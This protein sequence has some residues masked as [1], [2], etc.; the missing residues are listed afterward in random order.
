M[1]VI[2]VGAGLGGLMLGALLEKAGISYLILERAK[3]VK[4]LGSAISV[5]ICM[6]AVYKQLGIY[7]ELVGHSL[8]F[9][10]SKIHCHPPSYVQVRDFGDRVPRYGSNNYM[11]PRS[12]LHEVMSRLIPTEK[13]LYGKK[14]TSVQ[15]NDEGALVICNENEIY[16][17]DIIVGADG[18]YSSVRTSLYKQLKA[19]GQL[20]TEDD[21][22]PPFN[23]LC[24]VGTT[25]PLPPGSIELGEKGVRFEG[26]IYQGLPY[27]SMLASTKDGGVAWTVVQHTG[28]F[29]TRD[30]ERFKSSEWAAEGAEGMMNKIRDLPTA[31]GPPLSYFFDNTPKE[32][33]SKVMLE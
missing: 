2:I 21:T 20:P 18:A 26:M 10:N 28:S 14:V 4:P 23:T 16:H 7:D 25:P 22:D 27:V 6:A 33:I 12:K 29:V 17:G 32:A 30:E 11:L 31:F 8:P 15:Q 13:I 9:L 24:L 5:S 19:K 1:H 3:E